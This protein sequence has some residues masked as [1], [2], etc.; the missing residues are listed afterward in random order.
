MIQVALALG[1]LSVTV[2]SNPRLVTPVS[3]VDESNE[4]RRG[5]KFNGVKFDDVF[6]AT[7]ED[8]EAARHALRPYLTAAIGHERDADRKAELAGILERLG[9]YDWHCGGFIRRGQ[10]SLFCAFDMGIITRSPG[11]FFP[12]IAD[13]GIGVCRCIFRLRDRRIQSLQWNDSG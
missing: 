9:E 5:L 4:L 7:A 13:G 10:R 3:I 1:L 11:K 12:R 2:P 6:V 8:G